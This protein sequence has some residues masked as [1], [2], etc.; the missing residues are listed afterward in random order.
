[1]KDTSGISYVPPSAKRGSEMMASKKL[2]SQFN[3]RINTESD[4]GEPI[5]LKVEPDE[6]NLGT[7]PLGSLQ[8]TFEALDFVD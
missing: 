4:F 8:D 2:N 7:L 3:E 1:M 6:K 5:P